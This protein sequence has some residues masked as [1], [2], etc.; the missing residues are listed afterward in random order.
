M[1]EELEGLAR[2]VGFPLAPKELDEALEMV[3][4]PSHDGREALAPI[5]RS[6][7]VQLH[8]VVGFWK[9]A[10]RFGHLVRRSSRLQSTHHGSC[11]E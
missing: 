6:L 11:G 8:V 5:C 2:A 7:C 9:P 3:R 4:V 10:S 1:I